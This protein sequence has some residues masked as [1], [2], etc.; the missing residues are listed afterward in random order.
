MILLSIENYLARGCI[1]EEA[2]INMKKFTLEKK[3][4]AGK[5]N[6]FNRS[7]INLGGRVFIIWNKHLNGIIKEK[8]SLSDKCTKQTGTESLDW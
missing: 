6:F 4:I 2:V 3:I 1:E 7:K 8:P 5:A